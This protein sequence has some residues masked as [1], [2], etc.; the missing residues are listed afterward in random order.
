MLGPD[1]TLGALEVLAEMPCR[2]TA[3]AISQVRVLEC[4]GAALFDVMED[5]TELALA[6]IARL[7]SMRL[8]ARW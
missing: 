1:R 5:H 8:D 2:D 7:A 3:E 4:P 6:M